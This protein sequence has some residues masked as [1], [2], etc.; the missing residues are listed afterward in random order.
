MDRDFKETNSSSVVDT[1]I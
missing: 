1:S